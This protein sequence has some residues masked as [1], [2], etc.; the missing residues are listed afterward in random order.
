MERFLVI[1]LSVPL[2]IKFLGGGPAKA[3]ASGE[4]K[5][6]FVGGVT[7]P[8]FMKKVELTRG[9]FALVDDEDYDKVVKYKWKACLSNTKNTFY[10]YSRQ[11][12]YKSLHGFILDIKTGID[13]K[14]GN[15][16]NNQKSNLRSATHQ[17]NAANR[18]PQINNT[19]G[20][21]GVGKVRNK[22]RAYIKVVNKKIH[23]GYF[24]NV[25][26]AAIAYDQAAKKYFGE[27]AWLNFKQ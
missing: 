2:N 4:G 24:Q 18:G 16:L 26:G 8:S 23:L 3:L 9:K 10:A 14:D 12:G 6:I 20:Y 21:K 17:Q 1:C 22:F 5:V 25:E 15:G 7:F 19:T 13:H 27:F 11:D